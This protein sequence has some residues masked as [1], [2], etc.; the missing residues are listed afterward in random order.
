MMTDDLDYLSRPPRKKFTGFFSFSYSSSQ[1]AIDL[2]LSID[3]SFRNVVTGYR[4]IKSKA[5]DQ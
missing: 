5:L 1:S 3:C 4:A 2:Y